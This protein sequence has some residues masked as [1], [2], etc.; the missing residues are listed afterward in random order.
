MALLILHKMI[1]IYIQNKST[2]VTDA[3]IAAMLPA[4]Q[5][6]ISRDF[7]PIWGID[8]KLQLGIG[9]GYQVLLKDD[10]DANDAKG[11]LG[12]HILNG[13]PTAIIFVRVSLTMLSSVISHELLEMLADPLC[14]RMASD[15][16]H[17]IE[18]C[19]AVETTGYI[20]NEVYVSNFVYPAYFKMNNG[21]QY[22]YNKQLKTSYELLPGGYEMTLQG[23]QWISRFG[24]LADGNINIMRATEQGRRVFRASS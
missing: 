16:I 5:T 21:T 4:L 7:A 19:D 3:D 22:D 18:V 11:D 12:Y 17:I 20:I 8:A 6:Q 10:P 9:P 24:H 1:E 13:M 15:N 23:N 14:T 2:L